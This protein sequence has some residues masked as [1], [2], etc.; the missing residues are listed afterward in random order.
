VDTTGENNLGINNIINKIKLLGD[1]PFEEL[2]AIGDLN[3]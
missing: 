2:E 3:L 1:F